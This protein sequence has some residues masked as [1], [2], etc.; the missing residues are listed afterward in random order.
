[1]PLTLTIK[2]ETRIPIE[3]DEITP[4]SLRGLSN[5]QI[6]R[7][8]IFHGSQ[9]V[10]LGELFEVAGSEDGCVQF[11]GDLRSV[12][13]IGAKMSEGEIKIVGNT[14]RHV[15]SQMTGGTIEVSGDAGDFAGCEMTGGSIRI[16]GSASDWLGGGYQGTTSAMNGGQITVDGHAGNGVGSAMR[17]GMICVMGDVGK[18]VGW[19]MRAGSIFVGGKHGLE[20]GTGMIRGTILLN[21]DSESERLPVTFERSGEFEPTFL[22]VLLKHHSIPP[23]HVRGAYELYCGDML[24]GGRGEIFLAKGGAANL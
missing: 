6:A 13:W 1:M 2:S 3:V 9:Q 10:E 22:P 12:H 14:G 7:L 16:R 18:L 5:T 15:G 8:A 20:P 4:A 11:V 17:R 23:E 21:G 24:K 19:N